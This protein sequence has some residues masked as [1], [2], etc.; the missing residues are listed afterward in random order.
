MKSLRQVEIV[1]ATKGTVVGSAIQVAA[2]ARSRMVGLLG[3][4]KLEFGEGLLIVP[5][6]GV[7]T[8]GML[9]PIDVVALDSEMR[10]LAFRERLGAFRLAAVG[11]KTKRVLELPAGAIR[12]SQI[13][14][15]DQLVIN[16]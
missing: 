13:G 10:V 3:K 11:W 6:S 14:I 7:H 15:H 5:C 16:G 12:Q 4:R 8:W 9:F 1:N 2:T